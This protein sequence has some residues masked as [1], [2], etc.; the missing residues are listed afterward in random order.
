MLA[1]IKEKSNGCMVAQRFS[2]FSAHLN[3]CLCKVAPITYNLVNI[4]QSEKMK[5]KDS[6]SERKCFMI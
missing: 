5:K 1:V 2:D 3:S 4:S 6:E